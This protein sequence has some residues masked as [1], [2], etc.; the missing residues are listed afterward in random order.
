MASY[1]KEMNYTRRRINAYFKTRSPGSKETFYRI[2]ENQGVRAAK[3]MFMDLLVTD[4]QRLYDD[5]Q[6]HLALQQNA[7]GKV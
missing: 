2:L 6:R 1:R 3:G 4:I 7:E 5:K